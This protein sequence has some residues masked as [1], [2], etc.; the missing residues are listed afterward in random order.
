MH[1]VIKIN[2]IQYDGVRS[3]LI[4]NEMK[5]I[6]FVFVIAV[7][8]LL[9]GCA[10]NL[11]IKQGAGQSEFNQTRYTCLQQSQQGTS[12]AYIN[13]YGG[14]AS[15]GVITND[16]LF[17]AC[18][19]AAGWTLQDQ[20]AAQPALEQQQAQSADI[21]SRLEKI[22]QES[23]ALCNVPEFQAYFA[24]TPCK[25]S[26]ISFGQMADKTKINSKEKSA[27]EAL[28]TKSD[29]LMKDARDIIRPSSHPKD[30]AYLQYIEQIFVP[31][32]T[33]LRFDLY[34]GKITWGDYNRRRKELGESSEAERSKIFATK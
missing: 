21:K 9:S 17:I 7:I 16:G 3:S 24:K 25:S 2:I 10:N 34:D 28:S 14:V 6:L 22:T 23:L 13:R 33:K 5:K 32:T 30:Q 26:D 4:W 29:I 19:N 12:S 8:A 18:M 20:K 15:S 1:M 11:W 27:L 31:A